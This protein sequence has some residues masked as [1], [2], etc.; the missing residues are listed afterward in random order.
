MG[1]DTSPPLQVWGKRSRRGR[2]EQVQHRCSRRVVRLLG[3]GGEKS[4]PHV[5][6]EA[7]GE[8]WRGW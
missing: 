5:G 6:E 7:P 2:Y 1:T 8:M 3:V 4:H